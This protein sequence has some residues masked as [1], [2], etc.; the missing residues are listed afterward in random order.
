[1]ASNQL[2]SLALS[3]ALSIAG[4]N[5]AAQNYS[6][7]STTGSAT[8]MPEL[9]NFGYKIYDGHSFPWP[10]L[11]ED[12]IKRKVRVWENIDASAPA[13]KVFFR[14]SGNGQTA[15]MDAIMEGVINGKIKAY[16][17]KDDRFT[18]VLTSYEVKELM[19]NSPAPLS[20]KVTKYRIKE[21]SLYVKTTNQIFVRIVGIAPMTDV[22][23][24][25]GKTY[26][27]PLFWIYY[28]GSADF[29]YLYNA[30]VND[31]NYPLNWFEFLE[32]RNFSA[33]IQRIGKKVRTSNGV[34]IDA[35]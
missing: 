22:T 11:L 33:D 32:S 7:K 21:D 30:P 2:C 8:P 28:P 15:L 31:K 23:N 1:M 26:S 27:E 20:G 10:S 5:A 14:P 24:S 9:H 19:N 4:L 34:F 13:N 16:S 25:D 17:A 3:V 6:P 29:L 18:T 12:S 35:N